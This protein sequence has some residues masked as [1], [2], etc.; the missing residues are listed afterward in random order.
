MV[1]VCSQSAARKQA[2]KEAK[3]ALRAA[4]RRE[5]ERLKGE[6]E[7]EARRRYDEATEQMGCRELAIH[8]QVV[9]GTSR[10]FHYFKA[11]DPST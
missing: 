6:M 7:A 10:P 1:R 9:T 2:E 3:A 5:A 8:G 11:Q 4:Q